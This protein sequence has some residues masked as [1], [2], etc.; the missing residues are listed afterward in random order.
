MREALMQLFSI[1][2]KEYAWNSARIKLKNHNVCERCD[3]CPYKY[4]LDGAE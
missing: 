1:D 3:S 4:T 2:L